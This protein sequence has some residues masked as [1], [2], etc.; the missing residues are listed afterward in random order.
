MINLLEEHVIGKGFNRV[1][2]HHPENKNLCIKIN[3]R[4]G[5]T[6]ES[7]REQ[8]YCKHLLNRGVPLDMVPSYQGD[9]HTNLG[10][11]SIYKLILDDDGSVSQTLESYL[12]G[13]PDFKQLYAPY[14][15]L[16]S[17]LLKHHIITMTLHTR[18]ILC[19][20]NR[21]GDIVKFVICDDIGNSD[22][23]PIGNYNRYFAKQKIN[24]KLARF[25]NLLS[26]EFPDLKLG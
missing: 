5:E 22:L 13:T 25:E 1:C 16:K 15:A 6:K 21:E 26:T 17:Y 23:I 10:R 20:R 24:R 19:Q 7:I 8:K 14:T 12:S 4:D 9:T 11:G 2:Y 3:F 18:N